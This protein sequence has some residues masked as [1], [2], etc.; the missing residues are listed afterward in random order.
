[1]LDEFGELKE[2]WVVV[3]GISPKWCAWKV[4]AQVAGYFGILVDVDWNGIFKSFYE[5][6]RIKIACRDPCKIPFERLVE[7][8]KMI[9]L[10]FFTV[11]GFEQ[12]GEESDG[13]DDDPG[14]DNEDGKKEKLDDDLTDNDNMEDHAGEPFDGLDRANFTPK[15]NPSS[16]TNKQV[17]Q[18]SVSAEE[19]H[20]KIMID[21]AHDNF[22]EEISK[23]GYRENKQVED[24]PG[25]GTPCS[26]HLLPEDTEEIHISAHLEYYFEQLNKFDMEETDGEEED[27]E[28][29]LQCLP[30]D[31]AMAIGSVKRS[32]IE[33]MDNAESEKKKKLNTETKTA[34]GP[35]LTNRLKTRG[36]V[37]VK[38]MDKANAYL[39]KKNLEVPTTFKGAY[40][41]RCQM[42]PI[43]TKLISAA[44][45]SSLRRHSGKAV[46]DVVRTGY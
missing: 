1:M 46:A 34:W 38:I 9:Y 33:S 40:L 5:T 14:Q 39:L 31:L 21:E 13:N 29:K 23:S 18:I 20:S 43:K 3:D 25:F 30:E 32:L 4:F 27:M 42:C 2:A 28:T 16:K 19:F 11:E 22:L 36:H 26:Y 45:E 8:K 41:E 6:I 44:M 12:V 24:K 15:E 37:N 7:M 10:L 17:Q 35:V